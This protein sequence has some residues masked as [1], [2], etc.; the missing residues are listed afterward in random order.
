MITEPATGLA[1]VELSHEVPGRTEPDPH[2]WSQ[3]IS[4]VRFAPSRTGDG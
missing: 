2:V 3:A 1:F 4:L